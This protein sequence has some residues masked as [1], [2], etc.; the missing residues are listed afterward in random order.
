MDNYICNLDIDGKNIGL[1]IWDTPGHEGY[2][3]LLPFTYPET[4]IVLICFSIESHTSLEKAEDKWT[5][6]ILYYCSNPQVPYILVGCKKDLRNDKAVIEEIRGCGGDLVRIEEMKRR[7]G[8][9]V[10]IEEG[11]RVAKKIRARRYL[12]CSAKTGEGVEKLLEISTRMSLETSVSSR[13][14][15]DSCVVL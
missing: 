9:F 4:N 11:E 12:E 2:G 8:E 14:S 15:R 3:Y 6:E 5:P 7:G 10:A 1:A 13:R